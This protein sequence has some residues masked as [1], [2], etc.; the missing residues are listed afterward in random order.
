M[1]RALADM[2]RAFYLLDRGTRFNGVQVVT[3]RG[4][5]DADLLRQALLR[6][7]ARHPL[8]RVRLRGT[9][10]TLSFSD[11]DAAPLPLTVLRRDSDQDWQRVAEEELNRPFA[12]TSDHLT[13]L[14]LLHSP[15]RSD[16]VIAHHHV[17]ADALSRLSSVCQS[18]PVVAQCRQ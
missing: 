15:E 13:R 17:I 12:L 7:Q 8:L 11:E 2:E 3:L 18:R 9:D 6:L 14:T 1:E 16:L 10:R 5:V 4:P